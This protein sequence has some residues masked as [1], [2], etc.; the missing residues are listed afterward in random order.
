MFKTNV[1]HMFENRKLDDLATLH[2][3]MLDLATLT[4]CI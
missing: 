2:C 1:N 3:R 4:F